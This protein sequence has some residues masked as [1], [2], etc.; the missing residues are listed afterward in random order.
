MT[1]TK[2]LTNNKGS[3]NGWKPDMIVCH[4]AEGTYN[5]TISWLKNPL[6]VASAH[7]VVSKQGEITQLVDLKDAA[8]AQGLSASKIPQSTLKA[9]RDRN[10]NP[11]QY[12][13][14]IEH[15]GKYKDTRGALTEKQKAATIELIKFIR[16]EV[17]RIYGI[18]IPID[19]QHI[20]GHYEINPK[21]KPNCPGEKFPFAEIINALK[22]AQKPSEPPKQDYEKLYAEAKKQLETAQG[23]LKTV[24]AQLQAANNITLEYQNKIKQIREIV[25]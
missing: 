8:W 6:S 7:F 10:T 19:R 15:E 23:Q 24:Q 4:I 21:G 25:K 3:R 2:N 5:G 20:V 13:I 9:V 12:C 18:D 16:P 14:S 17:K 11:N 1:I 22:P